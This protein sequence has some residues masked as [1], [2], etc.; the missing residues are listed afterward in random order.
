M[1]RIRTHVRKVE[2]AIAGGD[3]KVAEAAL[4]DAMPELHRGV[5]TGVVHKRTA[6]RKLG[7]LAKRVK[8]L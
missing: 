5:K 7:R 8:A 3:K 6:A 2:D 4:H 1:S